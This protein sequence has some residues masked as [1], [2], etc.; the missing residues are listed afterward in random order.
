VIPLVEMNLKG[1]TH[2]I[3]VFELTGLK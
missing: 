1:K 3:D 2:P